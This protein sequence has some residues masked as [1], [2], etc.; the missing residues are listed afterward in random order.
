MFELL[1][2]RHGQS[3]N[4][5]LPES[6]RVPDPGLTD[7]GKKQA[8][9]L[10]AVLSRNPPTHLYCSAFRRALDTAKPIAEEL[11]MT[12][13]VRWDIFEQGGCY[14]GYLPGK[15]RPFRGLGRSEI[16]RD[17]TGWSIDG[18]ITDEGW[19]SGQPLESDQAAMQ[20]AAQVVRW[21]DDELVPNLSSKSKLPRARA[22]F[23]IHADF[24]VL[25]LREFVAKPN[26]VESEAGKRFMRDYS[27]PWNTSLTTLA[28]QDN[29]WTIIDYNSIDHLSHEDWT[30]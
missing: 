20:R 16:L 25:L 24:K 7:I 10:A 14:E 22:A 11:R 21:I 13:T 30:S 3:A 23:V 28:Y 6:Q 27:E 15:K 19:Y 9:R 8:A 26:F 2:I 29:A 12:P 1:L 18:R 17:Y 5:A 4:N